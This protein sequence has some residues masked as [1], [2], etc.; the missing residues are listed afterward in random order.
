MIT[1]KQ[2]AG[3][4]GLASK[5]IRYYEDAGLL[6][7]VARA[8]NGYRCYNNDNINELLFIKGARGAGF[9][10]NE[11]KELMVLFHNANRQSRE[12]KQLTL[13]KITTIHERISHLQQMA[14][15]LQQL[16]D[17]CPGDETSECAIL[18]GLTKK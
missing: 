8:D 2:A 18:D 12:V 13:D 15:S 5:T 4:T 14:A 3:Q 7:P 1:I 9:T 10:I 17:R 16:A 6:S 11:C